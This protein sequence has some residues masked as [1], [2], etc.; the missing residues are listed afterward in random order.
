MKTINKKYKVL[1]ALCLV[2]IG[3]FLFAFG[4]LFLKKEEN[5]GLDYNQTINKKEP[6]P[7]IEQ[8]NNFSFNDI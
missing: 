2:V 4:A 3:I 8:E 7:I 6:L 5:K 1:L